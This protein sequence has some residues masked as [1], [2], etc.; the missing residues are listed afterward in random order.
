[1]GFRVGPVAATR[2]DP[3]DVTFGPTRWGR[4]GVWL[5]DADGHDCY[6]S[7][8]ITQHSRENIHPGVR[9]TR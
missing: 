3:H 8:W 5:Q 6:N 4:L 9:C 7:Y 2:P 1:M